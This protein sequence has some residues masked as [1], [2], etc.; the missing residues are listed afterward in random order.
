MAVATDVNERVERLRSSL[1]EPLLVTNPTNVFYLSGFR[2]S[3]AAVLVESERVQLFTDFR[4]RE[5]A[6]SLE[7]VE[8]VETQ[9]SLVHGIAERVQGRIGFEAATM[10]YAN[11]KTLTDAGLE[12]VPREGL[13]EKLRAVKDDEELA[14]IRAA[15][16]ITDRVYEAFAQE[17][18]VGRSEKELAWRMEQLFHEEG[19]GGVSFEV[20]VGAG[21]TGALP[22]GRPTHRAVE[23]NTTVVVDAGCYV[24]G[25]ASDCTRTFAT[26]D[27]PDELA[28]AY[29][30]C[31]RAEEAGLEATRPGISG[32]DADQAARDVI[33]EAG[34]GEKF[35]HGLGH[36]V[37]LLVHEA[38]TLRQ[39]STDVLEPRNV[40]TVEPGIYL[41]G[42][43]GVR[44]EDLVVVTEDGNEVLTRFT[45]ELVTVS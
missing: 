37:G 38:P 35:G 1:G 12:L 5:A 17:R 30:V 15:A 18:F 3:N 34:L 44:I 28:R 31:A 45:K 9:R 36:G 33:A 21:P 14:K 10:T 23:A 22:H 4:Y 8:V 11:W 6:R 19:A 26:G 16:E 32:K 7:N 20:I 13:V 29:E 41:E 27:L 2:S 43:G 24:N 25:Y 40:V 39:E 42:N